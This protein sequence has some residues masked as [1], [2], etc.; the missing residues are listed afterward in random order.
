MRYANSRE[1]YKAVAMVTLRNG[2]VVEDVWG[3]YATLPGV[4]G[5]VT[6]Y[7][8]LFPERQVD[9]RVMRATAWEVVDE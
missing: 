7:R 3:P 4:R 5:Q 9:V 6:R 2:D 1:A 8:R